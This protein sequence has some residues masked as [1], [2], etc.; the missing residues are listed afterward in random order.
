MPGVLTGYDR[1]VRVRR[2]QGA[3]VALAV[4]ATAGIAVSALP[5]GGGAGAGNVSAASSTA[6]TKQGPDYCSHQQW[7]RVHAAGPEGTD[8]LVPDPAPYQANCEALQTAV[9]S[10]FPSAYVVP[11]FN[12]DLTLDPRV[13]QALLKKVNAEP[14]PA[15]R[16]ADTAKNFGSEL[17]SLALHP[18]DRAN[19]YMPGQY[20]LV[21]TAGRESFGA[22]SAVASN[23][24]P[25]EGFPGTA[26][27]YDCAKMPAA[28]KGKDQCT[29]VAVPGGW[30]AALWGLAPG[31]EEP[32]RQMGVLA[33]GRGTT[34]VAVGGGNDFQA[35]YHQGMY[36]TSFGWSLPGDTWINRWTGQTYEGSA[37]PTVHARTDQQWTQFLASP[38]LRK[39]AEGYPAYVRAT[40]PSKG[41]VPHPSGSPTHSH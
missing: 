2:Y 17:K 28:L 23:E 15:K 27:S 34:I 1:K 40:M 30:H 8:N 21:T 4:L 25:A 38:G 36:D 6:A 11:E 16:A 24:V 35:W 20:E 5:R 13:D 19:V 22:G 32:A 14:D 26:D 10:V 33:G 39:Y 37:P 12:A 31:G 7:F 3:G 9:R 29:P 41:T 18:E